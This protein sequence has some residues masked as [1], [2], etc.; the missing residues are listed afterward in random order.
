MGKTRFQRRDGKYIIKGKSYEQLVGSRAQ[1]WHK[2]A[3]KTSG[4]LQ[5]DNLFQN[6]LGRIVSRKKH[7]TAKK[8]KRLERAG[9][10]T[11][12]GHFGSIKSE[13][14]KSRKA[15]KGKKGKKCKKSRK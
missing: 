12:K 14:S 8:E 11:R 4:D 2:T 10:K 13:Q 7:L 5:K 15:R 3:F 9:Y 6:K 1:V